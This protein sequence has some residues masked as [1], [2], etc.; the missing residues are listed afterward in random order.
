[1]DEEEIVE[2]VDVQPTVVAPGIVVD[3]I[4]SPVK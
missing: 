2:Q 3:E 4:E 1:M